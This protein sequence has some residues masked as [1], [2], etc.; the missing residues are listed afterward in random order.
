[1]SNRSFGEKNAE[2]L[3]T[4]TG[5]STPE[6]KEMIRGRREDNEKVKEAFAWSFCKPANAG[7]RLSP[8]ERAAWAR[9]NGYE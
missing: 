8:E 6:V 4:I 5:I 3:G 9:A 1:M 7:R 2:L